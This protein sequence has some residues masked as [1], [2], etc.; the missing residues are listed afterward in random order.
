MEK[1]VFHGE[2]Q[3]LNSFVGGNNTISPLS[4]SLCENIRVSSVVGLIL[5]AAGT[6]EMCRDSFPHT[7]LRQDLMWTVAG[8]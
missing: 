1:A 2:T 4:F 3:T 8:L 6:A 5:L 7:A